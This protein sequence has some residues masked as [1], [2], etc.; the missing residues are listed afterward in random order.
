MSRPWL[1]II[2]NPW[3]TAAC[4]CFIAGYV[5]GF[6]WV[7]NKFLSWS[8]LL[9]VLGLGCLLLHRNDYRRILTELRDPRVLLAWA[10]IAVGYFAAFRIS[11]SFFFWGWLLAALGFG[12]LIVRRNRAE[13]LDGQSS[14]LNHIQG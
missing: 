8:G 10:A 11:G 14:A 7:S 1:T 12:Y 9:M 13:T 2:R 6:H 4:L 3:L 5:V